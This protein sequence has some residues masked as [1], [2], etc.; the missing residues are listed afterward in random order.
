MAGITPESGDNI[1][2]SDANGVERV[3][4]GQIAE[5]TE[6]NPTGDYGII[7]R[8]PSGSTE[9]LDGV[10]DVFTIVASGDL[11]V[12]FPGTA[13]AT[14]TTFVDVANT[15]S[16]SVPNAVL[17]FVSLPSSFPPSGRTAAPRF[18]F[19]TDGTSMEWWIQV[20]FALTGTTDCRVSLNA[21]AGSVSQSGNNAYCRY[22][23]LR[24]P[25]E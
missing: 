15:T 7:V 22:Y 13:G 17:A 11:S 3:V 4:I 19:S 10:S 25:S 21:V 6:A 24:Q 20:Q 1:I 2:V 9:I 12:A 5:P 14:A 18:G 16:G 8:D 23:I